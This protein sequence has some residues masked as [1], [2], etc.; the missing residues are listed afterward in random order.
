MSSIEACVNQHEAGIWFTP[1]YGL[2]TDRRC[3]VARMVGKT[4]LLMD[5]SMEYQIKM[6]HVWLVTVH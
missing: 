3:S 1:A 2:S 6:G 5:G 4:A